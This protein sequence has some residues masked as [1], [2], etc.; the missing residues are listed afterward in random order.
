MSIAFLL[1]TLVVVATPG[2]GVVYTLAAG[3]SRGRRASVVA[4]VGCTLGI[5]PHMLATVTGVAALLHTSA[6]AFQVLKYAGVAYLLYMAWATVRDKEAIT[7]DRET[8]PLSAGRVIVRGVL[9]NI[10]N[11]KLTIFFFAFLPQFVSPGEPHSV[12][13]MLGLSGVFMLV[14]FAVFAAY[15]VLAASVRRHVVSRPRVLTWL[16]RTF[17]GSFVALGA[18]LALT[19]R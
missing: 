5:V 8:T 13:R 9:I 18:K 3:L 15:G 6:T 11:P 12:V 10:L 17:A 7:V 4:A 2:T 14:T 1:T 19:A 16:R